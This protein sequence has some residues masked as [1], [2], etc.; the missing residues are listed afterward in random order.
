MSTYNLEYFL[1]DAGTAPSAY[2]QDSSIRQSYPSL[3]DIAGL[4][5]TT[6]T[7]K[8]CQKVEIR[9]EIFSACM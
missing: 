6:Y 9:A 1:E 7:D 8:L 4:M 2:E 5:A 3:L